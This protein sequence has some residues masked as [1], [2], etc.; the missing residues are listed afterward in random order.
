MRRDVFCVEGAHQGHY[1]LPHVATVLDL[2]SDPLLSLALG[3]GT[4]YHQS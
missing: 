2:A 1:K 3:L 4:V